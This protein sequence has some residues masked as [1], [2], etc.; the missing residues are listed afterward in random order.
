MFYV[1]TY[2]LIYCTGVKVVHPKSDEQ[3]QRLND[4]V[5]HILLFRS[6]EQVLVALFVTLSVCL[7]VCLC[8]LCRKDYSS[9]ASCLF[10][11]HF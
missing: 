8:E 6:L 11:A 9:E 4:A 5:K 3:R 10:G 7:S 2:L 1:L